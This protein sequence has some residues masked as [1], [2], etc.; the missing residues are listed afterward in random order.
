[1]RQDD[2]QLQPIRPETAAQDVWVHDPWR[3]VPALGG[4][5]AFPAGS[6]D[7]AA[8]D[9]RSDVLTYT[10]APLSAPWRVMGTPVLTVYLQADAPSFDLSAILSKV[11]PDGRV[12][13][14]SQGYG[15]GRLFLFQTA[16]RR[17]PPPAPTALMFT[18]PPCA[19]S[20]CP[21]SPPALV[22]NLGKPSG[23]A[24]P[25]RR[26][27]LI[28]SILARGCPSKPLPKC[29]TRS[30]PSPCST[31]ATAHPGWGCR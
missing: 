21:S 12:M 9:G 5:S 3:P 14:L 22:W 4:H 20:P 10:T 15:R 11:E 6:F 28:R 31:A 13:N 16:S 25:H 29:S 8:L 18:K 19:K 30:L 27:R 7:R 17:P 26:F 2:G 23:S 1:M 24:L